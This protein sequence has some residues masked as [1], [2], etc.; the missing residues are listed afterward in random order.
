MPAD[1]LINPVHRQDVIVA[2]VTHLNTTQNPLQTGWQS[3]GTNLLTYRK[4]LFSC[5]ITEE[6]HILTFNLSKTDHKMLLLCNSCNRR[7]CSHCKVAESVEFADNVPVS[8]P[9]K[10]Q[11]Q[12]EGDIV[13]NIAI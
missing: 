3:L 10:I 9:L 12:R 13:L 5:F 6:Y 11:R 7:N 2:L 1:L 8:V 4:H